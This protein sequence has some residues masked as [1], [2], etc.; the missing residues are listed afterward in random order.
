MHPE[1]GSN[2]AIN[3]KNNNYVKIFRHD[4]IVIFWPYFLSLAKVGYWFKF[5]VNIITGSA[6][7]TI[8]FYKG[9]TRY[10]KIGNTFVWVLCNIWRLWEVW[11]AIRF[12]TNNSNEMLLNG[13]KCQGYRFYR[14]R[15]IKWKLTVGGGGGGGVVLPPTN[16]IRVKYLVLPAKWCTMLNS[17]FLCRSHGLCFSFTCLCLTN[18]CRLH[19]AT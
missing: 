14:F 4:F 1:S 12:G 16:Q 15:I 2:L 9:L 13:A 10:P 5:H 18:S 17:Y 6:V 7:A 19:S 11:H 3:L 8:F